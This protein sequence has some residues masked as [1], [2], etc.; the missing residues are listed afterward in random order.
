MYEKCVTLTLL[1]THKQ[2]VLV[3]SLLHVIRIQLS[4]YDIFFRSWKHNEVLSIDTY[5]VY[6]YWCFQE[7]RH[8]KGINEK[9]LCF[10]KTYIIIIITS[11]Q[12]DCLIQKS[13]S[14]SLVK[15]FTPQDIEDIQMF[16]LNVF[17][18][19]SEVNNIYIS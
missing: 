5:G 2:P 17:Y 15:Y 11:E 1:N 9:M 18:F 6:L 14:I 4:L 10:I 8:R 13:S 16:M 3:D 12:S 19:T 7:K